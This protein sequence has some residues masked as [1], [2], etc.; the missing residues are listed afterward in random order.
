MYGVP[1]DLPLQ[2]FVGDFLSS[3]SLGGYSIHFNFDQHG[4]ISV[5]GGWELRSEAGEL[6]DS[7]CTLES[8]VAYR[9]HVILNQSVIGYSLDPPRSCSLTFAN[10]NQLTI[11]DDSPQY[12]CFHIYPDDIHV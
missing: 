11:Y 6:I 3:I 9:V 8:R 12:E 2:R 4:T 5:E 1:A 10:G 7:F